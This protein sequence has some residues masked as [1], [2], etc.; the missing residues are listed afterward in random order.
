[1]P[2]KAICKIFIIARDF[3][4]FKQIYKNTELKNNSKFFFKFGIKSWPDFIR[5]LFNDEWQSIF[6]NIV[7]TEDK[8]FISNIPGSERINRKADDICGHFFD[9]L[10]SGNVKVFYGMK[11]NGVEDIS[12]RMNMDVE[13]YKE[14]KDKVKKKINMLFDNTGNISSGSNSNNILSH[15]DNY[16]PIDWYIDFKSGYRWSS[17]TWYKK[18]RYGNLPGADVKVPWELSRCYH[19]ITLGQAYWLTGNE[20]YTE[21]FIYQ[22]IDWIVSNPFQ[23]GVN[24]SCTMDVAIR[25]CN[26]IL[27]FAYFKDSKLI[28]DSFLLEFSKAVYFHSLHIRN[29]LEKG[30]FAIKTNHYISDLV[31]LLYAGVFFNGTLEGKKW[32]DFAV[33]ELKKEMFYQVYPEGSD[34]EAS[35]FYHRLVLE[36]FLYSTIFRLKIENNFKKDNFIE[37]GE[38]IFGAEFFG[39]LYRMFEFVL[40]ALKPDGTMPQIGDNDNGRLHLFAWRNTLDMTYL[41]TIGSIFFTEPKFRI[42][43][44]GFADEALWIFGRKGYEIWQNLDAGDLNELGS[45]P[46]KD[47]GLYIMRYD[48]NYMAVSAGTNGQGGNGGHAHNDK[49]SFILS[50][51]TSDIIVDPGSYFYTPLPELRNMFRSTGFHNTVVVDGQEQNRFKNGNLFS[52]VNDTRVKVNA[53]VSNDNHDFLDTEHYGYLRFE[54]PVIHRRQIIFN[55][56]DTSWFVKDIFTGAGKHS[57]DLFFH[58]NNNL[59]FK[60]DAGNLAVDI[61]MDEGRIFKIY[62]PENSRGNMINF[63]KTLE[64]GLISNSYGEKIE[65]GVIIYSAEAEV[66]C[67]FLFVLAFTEYDYSKE[68]I[69]N[70]FKKATI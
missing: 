8:K 14:I 59:N 63:T 34:F 70:I 38:K 68:D 40:F 52:L 11:V 20:K 50:I 39:R 30:L 46:F 7:N 64:K 26:W 19:F 35:I 60:Y 13:D 57:F 47:C 28:N 55:K 21:E 61:N 48:K 54:N 12:Y 16:E 1:L 9:L 27:S 58:L 6:N 31:G 69:E 5:G 32:L 53:W 3:I 18:I 43:Q 24:W 44:F 45:K 23:M 36:L 15:G 41:L 42:K 10:G 37:I 33:R 4:A 56:Q 66:P 22:V 25:I 65:A 67:E 29:N 17:K 2:L 51:N 49:L 62:M